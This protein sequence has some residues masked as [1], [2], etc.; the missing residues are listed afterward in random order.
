VHASIEFE[1]LTQRARACVAHLVVVLQTDE[2]EVLSIVEGSS[3]QHRRPRNNR[4]QFTSGATYEIERLQACVEFESMS[5][6]TGTRVSNK[7]IH[8]Q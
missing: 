2:L 5:K 1:T 4:E 8:L 6:P 3:R 7:I